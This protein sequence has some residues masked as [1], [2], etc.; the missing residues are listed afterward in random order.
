MLL[1]MVLMTV[2]VV[3][4]CRW[5]LYEQLKKTFIKSISIIMIDLLLSSTFTSTITT[6]TTSHGSIR[7]R[8]H[9]LLQASECII[10]I[11]IIIIHWTCS[12]V[13]RSLEIEKV[14]WLVADLVTGWWFYQRSNDEEEEVEK[15]IG[16]VSGELALSGYVY[17]QSTLIV[18]IDDFIFTLSP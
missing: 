14:D 1:I 11:I 13:G 2:T 12:T 18:I 6:T 16:T 10:I 4:M 8:L 15:K 3:I 9:D 17:R 5:C 7:H